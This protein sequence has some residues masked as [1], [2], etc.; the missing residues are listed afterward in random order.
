VEDR[1]VKDDVKSFDLS[2]DDGEGRVRKK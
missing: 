2:R 1:Y